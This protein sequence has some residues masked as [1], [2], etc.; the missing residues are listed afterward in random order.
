[1]QLRY[2]YIGIIRN[3]L[4]AKVNR[5]DCAR[6]RSVGTDNRNIITLCNVKV[7]AR[8]RGADGHTTQIQR[9]PS[10]YSYASYAHFI[11]S[12]NCVFVNT[13]VITCRVHYVRIRIRRFMK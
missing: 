13:I 8:K 11:G 5:S 6:T 3:K 4:I 2:I 9:I 7:F 1:M 10:K 12:D